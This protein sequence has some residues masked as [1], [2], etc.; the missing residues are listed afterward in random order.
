V[1]PW[2]GQTALAAEPVVLAVGR[3]AAGAYASLSAACAAAPPG[4]PLVIEV[5][6][7]GPL[8]DVPTA[9]AGR[10]VTVRPA[11]GYRP[12]L[13]WD[14]P[15]TVEERTRA[16]TAEKE[17]LSF[18]ELRG[19]RLT[20]EDLD[21]A[22]RWPDSSSAAAAL[23]AVR[24]GDLTVT[25]CTFSATG[26]PLGGL[27]LV[28]FVTA[29]PD[30]GRCRLTRCYLRGGE[31]TAL[32]LHAP[33]AE[34]LLDGCLL[35]GGEPPL[36]HVRA[37]DDRPATLRAVRSTLVAGPTFLRVQPATPTDRHPALR[38]VG[39][40]VLV[41]H[42]GTTTQGEL[43][44]LPGDVR[45]DGVKW[46]AVNCLYAG[47]HNLL[48]G[49]VT[50]AATDV[51]AWHTQWDRS[52]GD[53]V[54][55][56]PWPAVGGDVGQRG[57]AAYRLTP[58]LPVAAAASA[59]PDRP[60][61]C[62]VE[63]LPPGRDN[64]PSFCGQPYALAPVEAPDEAAPEIPRPLGDQRYHGERLDLARITD[65]GEHLRRM[66]QTRGL[67]PRVVLLL[68][69]TGLYTM[70]PVHLSGRSLVLHLAPSPARDR[71]LVLMPAP[72][73][74]GEALFDVEGGSL[75]IRGGTLRMTDQ[76]GSQPLPWLIRVRGGDVRL[77]GCRLEGPRGTAG[78]KFHG[79]VSCAGTGKAH[80]LCLL[81][82][83]VL[84]SGGDAVRLAGG[85]R[86][87]AW[88][89]VLAAGSAALDLRPAGAVGVQCRLE[90]TTAAAREAVV[91]LHEA[92][93]GAAGPA[94]VVTRECAFLNPFTGR[95]SRPGLLLYEGDALAHGGL[96]WQ[97]DKDLYD[98]RLY[99]DAG[100][101][102]PD[103]P[104][105]LAAWPHLW[106]S[107]NV[108]RQVIEE[109][110]QRAFDAQSWA[111]ERLG[112]PRDR[113]GYGADLAGLGAPKKPA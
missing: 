33:G 111:P 40:D 14:V 100:R 27:A 107:A 62:D 20:L 15:R 34:V 29:G 67:G 35:A 60:L 12:L 77:S 16:G 82:R 59:A 9:V 23:A 97:S 10:D 108:R 85:M 75:E 89:T 66:E 84:V 105:P 42:S 98:R 87:D 19:G 22:V 48:A 80:Q 24:D 71:P 68:S 17:P 58:D 39:W 64:W 1:A 78:G 73:A 83:A 26:A 88:Q 52:E 3:A 31:A 93:A 37:G 8:F 18:L 57:A 81:R 69:G 99:F 104:E 25:N 63:A 51:P 50:I 4:R 47:W 11:K 70:T 90:R 110:L 36:L 102:P 38:W 53:D 41:S 46:E 113:A 65:L 30:K 95:T 76:A 86:L 72:R 5:R 54:A 92:G 6:D 55:A 79:L 106:G 13:L 44:R 32:D 109:R 103:K 96:L 21:L 94:V 49:D 45:S 61:G 56:E 101:A 74:S 7:D 43:L 112:L 28:R 91:R 2:Q